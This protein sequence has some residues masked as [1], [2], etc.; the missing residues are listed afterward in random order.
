MTFEVRICVFIHRPKWV[1]AI[2]IKFGMYEGSSES[3]LRWA[4][5][6]TSNEKRKFYNFYTKNTYM[7]ELLLNIFTELRHL[8]YRGIYF[9]CLFQRRLRPVTSATFIHVALT[10]NCWKVV[11]SNSSSGRYTGCSRSER[12]KGC[13]EGDQTIPNWNA[14][15]IFECQQL[16][17]EGHCH[18]GALH[19]K[20]AFHS[21]SEWT[22]RRFLVFRSTH[23]TLLWSLPPSALISCPRNQIPSIFSQ[24]S[25]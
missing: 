24:T 8:S 16:H 1:N 21:F 11:I 12:D 2:F 13:K 10:H 3:K 22:L 18:G 14:P 19:R 23:L 6:I 7:L 5:I 15:A 20:S 9:L 25:V 17:A 4:L